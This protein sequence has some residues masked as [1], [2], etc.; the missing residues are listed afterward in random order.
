M[1]PIQ[2]PEPHAQGVGY[3]PYF[4]QRG[5]HYLYPVGAAGVSPRPYDS[6][7]AGYDFS[8]MHGPFHGAAGGPQTV[9]QI[10]A[11]GYFAAPAGDPVTAILTD[12]QH[13]SRLGLD[14]VIGQIRRR[15]EI[16]AHHIE[17]IEHCK[18]AAINAIYLHEA[19]CGPGSASSRQHYAKHK[20]IQNLYAE[21]RLEQTTLWKDISR[22]KLLLPENAQQ[23]L[24]A[25]RKVA[26]LSTPAG[27]LP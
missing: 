2:S 21:Q 6:S 26:A 7:P 16:Y 23:Y 25:Q 14:D 9:E 22:L 19:Y 24:A 20:A 12:Q 10:V 17:Q 11:S 13:T 1:Y 5:L 3:I 18:C 15:Y 4:Y 8:Q 27:D